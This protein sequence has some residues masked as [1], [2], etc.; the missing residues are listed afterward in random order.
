MSEYPRSGSDPRPHPAIDAFPR[1]GRAVE[2]AYRE[3]DTA[4]HGS[5][6]EKKNLGNHAFLA[7]P[8][9]PPTC[10]DPQLRAEVWHWLDRVV[11]WVNHEYVWDV[12]GMIPSCWPR[13]PHLVHEI[14]VLADLRRSA[15]LALTGQALEEWQRYS[16][17][18]F[19]ERMRQRTKS[20]CEDHGHQPW[21]AQGRHTRHLAQ[22]SVDERVSV[23]Q[24]DLDTLATEPDLPQPESPHL[25]LVSPEQVDLVTGELLP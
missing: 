13:H 11:T 18:A 20:H 10:L 4:L 19:V 1:P 17:P 6:Q 24:R 5:E 9:D 2:Y 3:L 12:A 14:A 15:G 23:F 21:P 16:L 8:W 22:G 7:R 25:R